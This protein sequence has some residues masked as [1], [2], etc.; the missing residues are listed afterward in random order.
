MKEAQSGGADNMRPREGMEQRKRDEA[1]FHDRREF[2]RHHD[3]E[4]Y[5]R[6][7]RNKKYYSITRRS[8]EFVEQWLRERCTGKRL[9]DYC[10]GTGQ[11]SFQAALYGAEVTG[12]DISAESIESCLEQARVRELSEKMRFLVMDAENLQFSEQNFDLIVCSGVLHHLDIRKAFRELARVL[13]PD[14]Q[15]LCIEALGHNPLI[16]LYRRLTPSM[17]TRWEVDHIIKR[18]EL[19]I[20][21]DYFSD[22]ETHFYH[23]FSLLSVPF[24]NTV[25]FDPLLRALE[26]VDDIALEFPLIK[27]QAW[28]TVF[29]LRGPG[30]QSR[31]EDQKVADLAS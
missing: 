19:E 5:E 28:Q 7:T 30:R 8:V 18:R 22:V 3:K 20:A 2:L 24:R 12:I 16:N 15:I 9:L 21:R 11:V 29:I 25:L 26:K 17:R 31:L 14:G 27:Y 1:E 4:A 6:M 13:R 10:C 23:L